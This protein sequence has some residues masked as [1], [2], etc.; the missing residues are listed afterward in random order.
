MGIWM[1]GTPAAGVSFGFHGLRW[2]LVLKGCWGFPLS[3]PLIIHRSEAAVA[4]ALSCGPAS[5][6]RCTVRVTVRPGGFPEHR[7]LRTSLCQV[8]VDGGWRPDFLSSIRT[9]SVISRCLHLCFRM[10]HH[11]WQR[12]R[13]R[14][15]RR[16]ED[17]EG[18]KTVKQLWNMPELLSP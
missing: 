7:Q 4:H 14:G 13:S 6:S 18:K 10:D 8:F 11:D 2:R 17:D 3:F 5:D 1:L 9:C 12:G 16:Y 15:H